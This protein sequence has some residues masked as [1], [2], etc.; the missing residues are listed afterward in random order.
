[1]PSPA[2]AIIYPVAVLLFAGCAGTG[3]QVTA[4]KQATVF[5]RDGKVVIVAPR[6]GCREARREA[7]E[8]MTAV[9]VVCGKR[10]DAMPVGTAGR[11]RQDLGPPIPR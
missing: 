3:G 8:S 1:M 7:L 11:G 9:K 10:L 4:D 2:Q 5:N 6:D